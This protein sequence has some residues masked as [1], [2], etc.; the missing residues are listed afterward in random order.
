[1]TKVA[2]GA[3]G[4]W[5]LLT[6]CGGEA[7]NQAEASPAAT[8]EYLDLSEG[9]VSP[10][11]AQLELLSDG[12]L[13][14]DEYETAVLATVQCLAEAG[15]RIVSEPHLD[16]SGTRY[17]YQYFAGSNDVEFEEIRSTWIE[18]YT[19]H[20][21]VVDGEWAR[22][23]APPEGRLRDALLALETCLAESGFEFQSPVSQADF[24]T[25]TDQNPEEF[26]A[27]LSGISQEFGI[28]FVLN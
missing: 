15:V 28:P 27:C 16:L 6:A 8:H 3:L 18:C 17:V 10:L 12:V 23:T 19:L 7:S 21:A 9:S 22:Y 4:I 24:Q 1:M 14:F 26:T 13:T 5:L 20:Q 25:L 11:P 2:T